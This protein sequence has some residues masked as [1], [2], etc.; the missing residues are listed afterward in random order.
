[1]FKRI[2]PN[3]AAA[4]VIIRNHNANRDRGIGEKLHIMKILDEEEFKSVTSLPFYDGYVY[5]IACPC[6][7]ILDRKTKTGI[8]YAMAMH[9]LSGEVTNMLREKRGEEEIEHNTMKWIPGESIQRANG[10]FLYE[11]GEWKTLFSMIPRKEFISHSKRKGVQFDEAMAKYN[12]NY[13]DLSNS[14]Q[15]ATYDPNVFWVDNRSY[16]FDGINAH[17]FKYFKVKLCEDCREEEFETFKA[18]YWHYYRTH[19]L[20]SNVKQNI[21]NQIKYLKYVYIPEL[22]KQCLIARQHREYQNE[23]DLSASIN[24]TKDELR[25]WINRLGLIDKIHDTAISML[26]QLVLVETTIGNRGK[27]IRKYSTTG[28]TFNFDRASNALYQLNRIHGISSADLCTV[29]GDSKLKQGDKLFHG[30]IW[31]ENKA[32]DWL[33]NVVKEMGTELGI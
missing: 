32:P 26:Q 2:L 16:W 23:F 31:T 27:S 9:L 18:L 30:M 20:D 6:G 3:E 13:E 21:E 7:T 10:K 5:R 4:A 33:D 12:L 29:F 14:T 15:L 24:K 19:Y 8:E 22:E 25:R 11:E 28:K 17:L 1:V